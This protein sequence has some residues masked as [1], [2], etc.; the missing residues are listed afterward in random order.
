MK[1]SGKAKSVK[2][3]V[4]FTLIFFLLKWTMQ[5]KV[6]SLLNNTQLAL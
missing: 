3:E 2:P 5:V 4:I 1:E 6:L